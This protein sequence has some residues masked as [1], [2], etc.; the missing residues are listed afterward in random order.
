MGTEIEKMTREDRERRQKSSGE[1]LAC[2]TEQLRSPLE[3][4]LF[5]LQEGGL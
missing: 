5:V 3:M 2:H 4:E 1:L